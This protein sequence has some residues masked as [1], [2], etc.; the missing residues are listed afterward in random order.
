MLDVIMTRKFAW[1]VY[2]LADSQRTI[3]KDC[4]LSLEKP[5]PL[6][7]VDELS[8]FRGDG[9]CIGEHSIQVQCKNNL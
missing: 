5:W 7:V 3:P 8:I 6:H 9:G 2:I 4:H 1:M